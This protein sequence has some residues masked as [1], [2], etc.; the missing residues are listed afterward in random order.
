MTEQTV[1]AGD[2][3]VQVE[4]IDDGSGTTEMSGPSPGTAEHFEEHV[5]ASGDHLCAGS[6]D[7]VETV[8]DNRIRVT[9]D[10]P[11]VN[12]MHDGTLVAAYGAGYRPIRIE[13][14]VYG[15]VEFQHRDA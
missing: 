4:D 8:E 10:D 11:D 2:Q 9:L 3:E 14:D 6:V 12:I 5:L 1:T 15:T 7:T 13:W